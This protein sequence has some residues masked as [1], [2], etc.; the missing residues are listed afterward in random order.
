MG[1]FFNI[2]AY[3]RFEFNGELILIYGDLLDEHPDI[4]LFKF[5]DAR[6]LLSDESLQ[7]FDPVHGFGTSMVINL[8]VF[9]HLLEPE[10]LVGQGIV[11][12]LIADGFDELLLQFF[13]SSLN[14]VRSKYIGH[15]NGSGDVF[16]QL[17]QEDLS[18]A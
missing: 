15:H 8:R 16:L 13:R 5:C 11:V 18:A 6:F 7:L 14:A 3:A 17:F 4:C 10:N 1:L 12:F 2:D 9:L